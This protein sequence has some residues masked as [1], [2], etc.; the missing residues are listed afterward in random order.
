M[1]R[2]I[3]YSNGQIRCST[4]KYSWWHRGAFYR[5]F[6]QSWD[7]SL[8]VWLA[9]AEEM[10]PLGKAVLSTYPPAFEVRSGL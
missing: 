10:A 8:L 5:R 6:A 3:L 1:T 2:N 7:A 9:Q 4:G